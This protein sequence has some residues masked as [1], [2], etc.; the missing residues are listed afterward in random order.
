MA[1]SDVDKYH[2]IGIGCVR[3]PLIKPTDPTLVR[4]TILFFG[5]ICCS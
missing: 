5:N 4:I 2:F 1:V 3:L